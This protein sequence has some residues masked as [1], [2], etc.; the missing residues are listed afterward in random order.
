MRALVYSLAAL[1]ALVGCTLLGAFLIELY[2]AGGFALAW[3]LM[4]IRIAQY[5]MLREELV[6]RRRYARLKRAEE[7]VELWLGDFR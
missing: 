2:Y 5:W 3:R 7:R 1:L 6:L 4:K